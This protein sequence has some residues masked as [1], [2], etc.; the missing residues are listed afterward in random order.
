MFVVLVAL[1]AVRRFCVVV[2][3]GRVVVVVVRLCVV[4]LVALAAV[5][6]FC[7]V[8]AFGR[9]VVVVVVLGLCYL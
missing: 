4:V 5:R 3:F 8:V 2:A 1:A 6:R 7:V 9:V